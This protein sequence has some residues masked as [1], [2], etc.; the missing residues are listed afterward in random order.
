MIT[1][2]AIKYSGI[3]MLIL[4][5]NSSARTE[6]IFLVG[7]KHVDRLFVW[8]GTKR[9]QIV[10]I[11]DSLFQNSQKLLHAIHQLADVLVCNGWIFKLVDK[12]F[13]ILTLNQTENTIRICHMSFQ[14]IRKLHENI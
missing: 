13:N 5:D 3:E 7:Y 2:N 8:N 9:L 14:N 6:Y 12:I 1:K 11:H 10:V 4:E